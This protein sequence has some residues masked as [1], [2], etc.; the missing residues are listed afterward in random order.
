MDVKENIDWNKPVVSVR[1]TVYNHAKYLRQ[2]L[3][4]FIMQET[5]FPFEVIVHDDASTDNSASIIREYA[6]KY[7]YIIK[8]IFQTENQ[9]SKHDGSIS[10]HLRA[11]TSPFAKYFAI[12]EGDDYW[13]DPLKLQKQVDFLENNPQY[14]L[15]FGKVKQ[16]VQDKGIFKNKYFGKDVSSVEAL[17]ISNTI[18][19]PTI[20]LRRDLLENYNQE[21]ENKEWLAGDYPLWL[22][23][24]MYSKL[25]FFNEVFA[26][27]RILSNSASH[28]TDI[29]KRE[30]FIKSIYEMKCFFNDKYSIINSDKFSDLLYIPLFNNAYS[31][32]SKKRI[33]FYYK[34]I[35]QKS[36]K[37]FIKR[38][39]SFLN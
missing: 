19:T 4:G 3:D 33:S 14:G 1:C 31:F 35:K 20:L 34:K 22:Y 29:E 30:R 21:I 18:P 8:P 38:V 39:I 5:T 27:Y 16:Y 28:S 9:Y 37:I 17:F 26:V 23:I 7:P 10:K 2:C 11:A 25:H 6:N 24:S 13:I 32:K 12:C 36:W 15:T